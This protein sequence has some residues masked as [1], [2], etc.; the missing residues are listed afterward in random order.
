LVL[1]ME[2]KDA[3]KLVKDFTIRNGWKDEP[4]IDKFDHIH[5]ELIEM[6]QHLRYLG[7]EERKA[8]V[9]NK[10]DVF[11]D[12]IGDVLFGVFRLANQLGIDADRAFDRSSQLI[13]NKYNQK[14]KENNI[15]WSK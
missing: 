7:E 9:A 12:G 4:N 13:L 15:P 1:D 10:Q 8:I 6:S 14:K 5:E 3:Q 11:E 2:I